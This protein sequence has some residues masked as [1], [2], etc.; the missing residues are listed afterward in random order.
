MNMAQSKFEAFVDEYGK[1]S[2][3]K[4]NLTNIMI[5][6]SVADDG[7]EGEILPP[8]AQGVVCPLPPGCW[9]LIGF[10][11]VFIAMKM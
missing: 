7:A 4:K 5:F 3:E 6:V 2:V 8:M 10:I 11:L 1:L 9:Q